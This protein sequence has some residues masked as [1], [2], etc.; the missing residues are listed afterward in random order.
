M[1]DSKTSEMTAQEPQ[2]ADNVR[3]NE[4]KTT[5]DSLAAKVLTAPRDLESIKLYLDNLKLAIATPGINNIAVTG[6]YGSGKSTLLKTFQSEYPSYHYLNISLASFKDGSDIASE[7]SKDGVLERKLEISILQQMFYH[8][9]PSEI[10]D[11]RFKRIVNITWQ[12]QLALALWFIVWC[13]STFALFGFKYVERLNPR[14][15]NSTLKIDWFTIVIF[16]LF[17]AGIGLFIKDIYR[18]LSNSKINKLSIKGELE[19]GA[20]TEKSV[21][22][23]HLEEILYFF[24]RTKFNVI[25]IEDIDRFESTDIFT[26]LREINTLINNSTL[27]ERNIKFIYAV[28]DDIFRDKNERVKFFEHI[29]PIIPFISPS[30]ANEQLT[31][32]INEAGLQG[33]ISEEFRADI[34][35]FID[36]IDMRL[37]KNIFQEYQI[38]RSRQNESLKQE[39]LFAILVY[40]NLY[41]DDFGKLAKREG[42]LFKFLNQKQEFVE[43]LNAELTERILEKDKRINELEEEIDKPIKELRAVYIN[44]IIQKLVR[45]SCFHNGSGMDI[46]LDEALEDSFFDVLK[47]N[48]LVAYKEYYGNGHGSTGLTTVIGRARVKLSDVEKEISEL[49]Y[50]ERENRLL[51]RAH[52]KINFHKSEREKLKE[53][54][55]EIALMS[56]QEI[57]QLTNIKEQFKVFKNVG[58]MRNLLINGY[59]DEDYESYIS[60]FHEVALTKE[61]FLFERN[62]RE[63][64]VNDFSY[65]LTKIGE[66]V[67]KLPEKYF[68]RDAILN[69][70]LVEYLLQNENK[71]NLEKLTSIIELLARDDENK[72][73]FITGFVKRATLGMAKFIKL[74]CTGKKG[75]WRYIVQK[76]N[77]TDEEIRVWCELIFSYADI[78]SISKFEELGNLQTYLRE[79]ETPITFLSSF[80]VGTIKKFIRIN[81]VKFKMLNVAVT[82]EEKNVFQ[83]VLKN[84]LYQINVD[85]IKSVLN[86]LA[87]PFKDDELESAHYTTLQEIGPPQLLNYIDR[88]MGTYCDNVLIKLK[89]NSK[90]SEAT[91]IKL[92]NRTDLSISQ[93]EL[94]V[95]GRDA[96][97]STISEVQDVIVKS[98]LLKE[99]KVVANWK[100]V[101]DYC[102][103]LDM[104]ESSKIP[105]DDVVIDFLNDQNNYEVLAKQKLEN[106]GR[107]SIYTEQFA[108]ALIHCSELDLKAFSDLL[109]VIPAIGTVNFASLTLE[110]IG[111]LLNRIMLTLSLKNYSGLEEKKRGLGIRLFETHEIEFI[112]RFEEFNLDTDALAL[113][114][115]STIS[116]QNKLALISKIDDSIIIQSPSLAKEVCNVLADGQGMLVR[117]EVLDAMVVAHPSVE[118]RIK[119]LLLHSEALNNTQMRLLIEKLGVDYMKIFNGKSELVFPLNEWNVSLFKDLKE[120][121]LIQRTRENREKAEVKIF[122]GDDV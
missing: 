61:D 43:T 93:K 102:D 10:P 40:K 95:S 62:V 99:N 113:V 97:L 25:I 65:N 64:N 35:A 5:M 26:K 115:E 92:L 53:R 24:E 29:L 72:F 47:K 68:K 86:S 84:D 2:K 108:A 83:F 122:I 6:S 56:L 66:L 112:Q 58:L 18:L 38:Y 9:A 69:F 77:F 105:F 100:N 31:I 49:S 4:R 111:E 98:I 48:D 17:L 28:K 71:D 90:E 101:F 81:S 59:I 23:Q 104:D 118:K 80:R 27:I 116:A 94:I 46:T 42:V 52:D 33:A 75:L 120:R 7:N 87:I 13:V 67:R 36:D 51:D 12:K 15:W 57:L 70:S 89:E 30:N 106:G 78:D 8:V 37:L 3:G 117:F 11:S 19:L 119:L 45:F 50:Q 44:K 63:G 82:E 109:N 110:K 55:R 60:L 79:L 73:D 1:T 14:T 121:K 76:S 107:D 16:I 88:M 22:N 91:I 74:I 20:N 41:P 54:L 39:N 21:F 85:N 34:I 32:L 114:F 103:S 96:E